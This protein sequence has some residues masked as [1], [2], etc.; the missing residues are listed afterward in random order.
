MEIC[1][2]S[3]HLNTQ[4]GSTNAGLMLGQRRRPWLS[5]KSALDQRPVIA[6][7]GWPTRR[8]WIAYK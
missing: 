8:G 5:I 2:I 1:L 6:A 4:S 7:R 3:N